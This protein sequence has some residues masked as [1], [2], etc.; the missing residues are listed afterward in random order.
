M[1]YFTDQLVLLELFIWCYDN[2]NLTLMLK[3][4]IK[5]KIATFTFSDSWYGELFY[6]IF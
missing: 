6:F 1:V 2:M 5:E 4:E 3:K